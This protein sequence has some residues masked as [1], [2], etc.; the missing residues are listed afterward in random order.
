MVDLELYVQMDQIR[1]TVCTLCTLA[2]YSTPHWACA[3]PANQIASAIS[4]QSLYNIEIRYKRRGA[5][6]ISRT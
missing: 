4:S 5:Y 6:I 1:R 3:L 2:P